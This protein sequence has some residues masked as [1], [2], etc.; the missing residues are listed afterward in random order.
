MTE[1]PS[2]P[3][4]EV[5]HYPELGG[6]LFLVSMG[7]VL[8]VLLLIQS[9]LALRVVFLPEHWA[10]VTQPAG[11]RYHPWNEAFLWFEVVS[12]ALLLLFT[13]VVAGFYFPKRRTAPRLI[14]AYFVANLPVAVIQLLLVMQIPL[15]RERPLYQALGGLGLGILSCLIWI[16]YFLWS[17]RVKGTFV[18]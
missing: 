18:H 16:P 14:I 17:R 3:Q 6:P 4:S 1:L 5:R 7:L 15:L 12:T 9:L 2:D 10:R 8:N 11:E 13:L